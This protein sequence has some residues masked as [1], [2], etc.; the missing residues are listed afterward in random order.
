MYPLVALLFCLYREV[1]ESHESSATKL[2]ND[3]KFLLQTNII[4]Y[5]EQLETIMFEYIDA[6]ESYCK[7]GSHS[8]ADSC[9]KRAQLISLQIH[10]LPIN[11]VIINLKDSQI[12]QFIENHTNF[13]EV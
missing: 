9:A 8:H 5:R 6:H 11:L 12:T 3:I 10:Y 1:A 13:Y 2:L 7:A 4:S